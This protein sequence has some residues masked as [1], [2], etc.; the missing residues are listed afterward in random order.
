MN[1]SNYKYFVVSDVHSFCH[2]LKYGLK[3]ARFKKRNKNHIL[4]ILGDCFDRGPETLET[5]KYI[6]SIPKSRRILIR[7]NHEELYKELL[8]KDYPEEHD[9][10]NGTVDTFCQIAGIPYVLDDEDDPLKTSDFLNTDTCWPEDE[11]Y[12]FTHSLWSDI[13]NKV[14][15]HEI[16]KWINSDEWRNY[17]EL[18]KFIFV[19]SFIPTKENMYAKYIPDWREKTDWYDALWCCPFKY[20]LRG[21]FIPEEEN[22]KVLVCGHWHTGDFYYWLNNIMY[23]GP[24]PIYYS[25]GL[26]GIDGGCAYDRWTDTYTHPQNVLV[27]DE[28]FE[29]YDKYN[30]KLI[31]LEVKA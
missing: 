14:A 4:I 7:G 9:F 27:I 18:D 6:K 24:A 13:K 25:K 28:N 22:G 10:S 31:P 8:L 5:Y 19:H 29:C 1:N 16:T 30:K 12:K 21:A 11:I 26:I 3:I 15:A 23:E 17:Y 2:E 20:Y